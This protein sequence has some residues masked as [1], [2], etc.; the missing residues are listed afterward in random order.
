LSVVD[1]FADLILSDDFAVFALV[2]LAFV[3]RFPDGAGNSDAAHRLRRGGA[4][5]SG[6]R[7]ALGRDVALDLAADFA[8]ALSAVVFGGELVSY[9]VR[10]AVVSALVFGLAL[11]GIAVDFEGAVD[12]P[13]STITSGTLDVLEPH[14]LFVRRVAVA[15][16]ASLLR[17]YI[18]NYG[19]E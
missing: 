14:I 16:H 7:L 11:L 8:D 9:V 6:R 1:A 4:V 3:R 17:R 19:Y 15:A 10:P 2:L 5:R 12:I 18:Q 13:A